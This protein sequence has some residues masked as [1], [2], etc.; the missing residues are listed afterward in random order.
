MYRTHPIQTGEAL[1]GH[2]ASAVE[3]LFGKPPEQ[4]PRADGGTRWLYP[5]HPY[6]QFTSAA[7]VDAS[8]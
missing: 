7:D 5:T 6:G 3:A 1:I 8:G 2:P 4:Y